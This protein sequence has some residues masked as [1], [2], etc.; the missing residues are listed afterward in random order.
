MNVTKDQG[1]CHFQAEADITS[2]KIPRG[3]FFV[4]WYEYG[5]FN[6]IFDS[7]ITMADSIVSQA[8]QFI[9]ESGISVG[10]INYYEGSCYSRIQHCEIRRI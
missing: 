9:Y 1:E 10:V 8:Y 5:T 6:M 3:S 2:I 4:L 7:R